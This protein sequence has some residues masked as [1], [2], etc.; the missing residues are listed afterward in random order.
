MQTV[1]TAG[2]ALLAAIAVSVPSSAEPGTQQHFSACKAKV[3]A[4]VRLDRRD[5]RIAARD[6]SFH[7]QVAERSWQAE[8]HLGEVAEPVGPNWQR[9]AS[10]TNQPLARA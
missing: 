2:L 7:R 8:E 6:V 3:T 1:L 10:H 5:L 9:S 4:G